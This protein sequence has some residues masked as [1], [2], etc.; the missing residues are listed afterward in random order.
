MKIINDGT[1]RFP[2]V[3]KCPNNENEYNSFLEIWAE[4][5]KKHKWSLY[6]G[7]YTVEYGVIC[8][9][10]GQFIA[11]SEDEISEQVREQAEEI[12]FD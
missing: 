5:I 10:C 1:D 9:I 11:V 7:H 6:P 2:I 3:V 4:D 8:P 12:Q